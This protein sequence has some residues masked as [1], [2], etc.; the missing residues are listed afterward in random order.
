MALRVKQDAVIGTGRTTHHAGD[1]MVKTP[2]GETGDF[3]G[4][5]RAEAALFQPEKAKKTGAP[6]RGPHMICFTFLEVGLIGRIVGIRI[7]S[8]LDMSTYGS[9]ASRE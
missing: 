9:G 8:N 1:A 5:H 6:K 7:A 2:P 3:G 4:A